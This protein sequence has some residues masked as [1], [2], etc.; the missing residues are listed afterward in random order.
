MSTYKQNN[1][2]VQTQFNIGRDQVI[3]NLVV[4]GQFLDFAKVEGLLPKSETPSDFSTI[5]EAFEETFVQRLGSDLTQATA[6]AGIILSDV[7]LE[8]IP[9]QLPAA[10]PIKKILH[11]APHSLYLKL[12]NLGYWDAFYELTYLNGSRQV[13]WLYSL[14][15]LWKKHFG[16]HRLFGIYRTD[17]TLRSASLCEAKKEKESAY[18]VNIDDITYDKFRVIMAGLA[19]DLIRICSI[20][21]TDLQFWEG[22]ISLLNIDRRGSK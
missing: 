13:V 22:I 10:L 14:D 16:R 5:V 7:M 19:V 8:Y 20:A 9:K 6:H 15:L 3:H 12:C 2:S 4:V 11:E 21:S 17:N 1:Q 18:D